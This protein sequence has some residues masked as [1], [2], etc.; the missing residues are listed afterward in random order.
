M[1]TRPLKQHRIPGTPEELAEEIRQFPRYEERF[2]RLPVTRTGRRYIVEISAGF[3][4]NPGRDK[5][6]G[7][8]EAFVKRGYA[9]RA[10]VLRVTTV[11][12]VEVLYD[13]RAL[14]GPKVRHTDD[15]HANHGKNGRPEPQAVTQ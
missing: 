12:T 15:L 13:V 8:A 4:L 14:R 2:E 6:R 11:T 5:A 7:T 9:R 1:K 10:R 3:S